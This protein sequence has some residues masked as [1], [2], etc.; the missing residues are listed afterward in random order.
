MNDT[1]LTYLGKVGGAKEQDLGNWQGKAA[2]LTRAWQASFT[3]KKR[4]RDLAIHHTLD[5][6]TPFESWVRYDVHEMDSSWRWRSRREE[7]HTRGAHG[8][9]YF[10]VGRIA[11]FYQLVSD[12]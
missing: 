1:R 12:R 2:T 6:P 10:A 5:P 4:C 3:G 7:Q 11:C 8:K 9:A